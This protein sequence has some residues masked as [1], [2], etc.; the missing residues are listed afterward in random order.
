M[1]EGMGKAQV[2]RWQVIPI[3]QS[4]ISIE[5]SS[6]MGRSLRSFEQAKMRWRKRGRWRGRDS[7][8]G[9]ST[10][11]IRLQDLFHA[12]VAA[13]VQRTVC[14]IIGVMLGRRN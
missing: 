11:N 4:A 9:E 13:L 6:G 12:L 10:G 7:S 1:V 14:L 2:T 5:H 3:M 8:E